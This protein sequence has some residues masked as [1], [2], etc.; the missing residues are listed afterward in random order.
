MKARPVV[1]VCALE[2]ERKKL[3]RAM[4]GRA[5]VVCSGPGSER[6]ARCVVEIAARGA[7]CVILAGVAGGLQDTAICP[8]VG[9]VIDRSGR[10]W[11]PTIA[12]AGTTSTGITLLGLD[13]PTAEPGEK[14]ALAIAHDAQLVDCESHGFAQ[15][16]SELDLAWGVVRGV[17]D[18]PRDHLPPECSDWIDDSGATR[19]GRVLRDLARRPS[20]FGDTIRLGR[21]AGRAMTHVCRRVRGVVLD[22]ERES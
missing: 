21:R 18:G 13:S 4:D 6:A 10:S 1:I 22:L 9:R 7:G 14:A 20:L 2:F 19:S 16:A 8:S 11:S 12:A 17:S 5:E 15:A 3:I